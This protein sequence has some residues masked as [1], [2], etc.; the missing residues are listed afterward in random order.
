MS[1]NTERDDSKDSF[2]GLWEGI[3]QNQC[4]I[5]KTEENKYEVWQRDN[6]YLFRPYQK[7]YDADTIERNSRKIFRIHIGEIIREYVLLR[8]ID[9]NI[10]NGEYILFPNI[11][12]AFFYRFIGNKI[13]SPGLD[14][15]SNNSIKFLDNLNNEIT[16]K[17][18]N[19]SLNLDTMTSYKNL[20][21]IFRDLN[22]KVNTGNRYLT[23]IFSGEVIN[24]NRFQKNFLDLFAIWE[25]SG[26]SMIEYKY[27]IN[28]VI[29]HT[30]NNNT[31]YNFINVIKNK[32]FYIIVNFKPVVNEVCKIIPGIS[33]VKT[34]IFN[35]DK[36]NNF[37]FRTSGHFNNG[38]IG[39]SFVTPK[40]IDTTFQIALRS[41]LYIKDPTNVILKVK[42]QEYLIEIESGFYY[43][44]ELANII[45]EKI[46]ENGITNI[47]IIF[48]NRFNLVTGNNMNYEIVTTFEKND[49]EFQIN[50]NTLRQ[51]LNLDNLS[52]IGRI[53]QI[54][55][56]FRTVENIKG[57]YTDLSPFIKRSNNN[58]FTITTSIGNGHFP[59][60]YWSYIETVA[61]LNFES[62]IEEHH[63][64][65]IRYIF[66]YNGEFLIPDN[67]TY[68]IYFN[69]RF[70]NIGN[71][72][73]I[74][75][76]PM[77]NFCLSIASSIN[78]FNILRLGARSSLTP[79]VSILGQ[80]NLVKLRN[81][82]G[83]LFRNYL[84]NTYQFQYRYFF[85]NEDNGNVIKLTL[86]NYGFFKLNENQQRL[87]RVTSNDTLA[88]LIPVLRS[89]LTERRI[90]EINKLDNLTM[91]LSDVNYEKVQ[92]LEITFTF[93]DG[94]NEIFSINFN[95]DRN[96]DDE[97][98]QY[99][100][101][102]SFY[103]ITSNKLF[104]NLSSVSFVVIYNDDD[105]SNGDNDGDENLFY[106]QLFSNKV[107]II[108]KYVKKDNLRLSREEITEE[109]GKSID[110]NNNNFFERIN[111]PE[112][113]LRA[114]MIKK[115][116]INNLL[117][118]V[119]KSSS[120]TTTIN[121]L[122]YYLTCL[123]L[124]D[125]SQNIRIA[126]I[127][128][129]KTLDIDHVIVDQR[130]CRG[131]NFEYDYIPFGYNKNAGI[132]IIDGINYFS[133]NTAPSKNL[134]YVSNFNSLNYLNKV[135]S[136]LIPNT[137]RLKQF[138]PNFYYNVDGETYTNNTRSFSTS[139]SIRNNDFYNKNDKMNISILF[140]VNSISAARI[141]HYIIN[142]SINDNNQSRELIV[143]SDTN[144]N[145]HKIKYN[146]SRFF[147][148][149]EVEGLFSTSSTGWPQL[150]FPDATNSNIK[151][152]IKNAINPT[153]IPISLR[154]RPQT[155][156]ILISE[157][158][159]KAGADDYN[160]SAYRLDRLIKTSYNDF[161]FNIGL[162]SNNNSTNINNESSYRDLSLER[163]LLVT[164][165]GDKKVDLTPIEKINIFK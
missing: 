45:N 20:W 62:N 37:N 144:T 60:N 161:M 154:V 59:E 19:R 50:N 136:D 133:T 32:K 116:I 107:T 118:G 139:V 57:C 122:Y 16:E 39:S 34:N 47:T 115:N 55:N 145:N 113:A 100:S 128:L 64:M 10:K 66:D 9:N 11:F 33:R 84:E 108:E 25:K 56:R 123:S 163:T 51:I 86:N 159:I 125:Y 90:M 18:R 54:Y 87:I 96:D 151:F 111:V 75:T 29:T 67:K 31:E 124:R 165:T 101:N 103:K 143:D 36:L 121:V 68:D 30:I 49:F 153:S 160:S 61:S 72:G 53:D 127:N 22:L 48:V 92:K 2:C 81:N 85:Y 13:A 82:Y 102:Q 76:S 114:G 94:N 137:L 1:Y 126:L 156:E 14:Y 130:N 119:N 27:K 43:L 46:I 23:D 52:L 112:P 110:I 4:C 24:V 40:K 35:N 7:M 44:D 73:I 15:N 157:N 142:N 129:S 93:L 28:K 97:N 42:N 95:E 80:E 98:I 91:Q 104:K 71:Y 5:I 150:N 12:S 120:P 79:A 106:V 99:E 63:D 65:R 132:K 162:S 117:V 38:L 69:N 134:N 26:N 105:Y 141:C 131:G 74:Y 3:L 109:I 149:G 6:Y 152:S 21:K 58:N 41:P 148:L 70:N 88:G 8:D 155:T 138:I 146:K 78:D 147:L 77:S 158:G 135:S 140:D 17:Y 164:I 89:I 83:Y